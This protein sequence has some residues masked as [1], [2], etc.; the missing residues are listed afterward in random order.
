MAGT[1]AERRGASG[2][3]SGED[4]AL[5]VGSQPH[6]VHGCM[7]VLRSTSA[8]TGGERAWVHDVHGGQTQSGS[9]ARLGWPLSARG[10]VCVHENG[11]ASSRTTRG[12]HHQVERHHGGRRLSSP[13]QKA[14]ELISIEEHREQGSGF[15]P[16]QENVCACGGARACGY[17]RGCVCARIEA[18]TMVTVGTT[19][20]TR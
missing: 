5:V 17:E 12:S 13:W 11:C 19:A 20:A 10:H 1:M 9:A 7:R 2:L 15:F 18:S 16:S 8:G 4:L 3:W 6:G 14:S